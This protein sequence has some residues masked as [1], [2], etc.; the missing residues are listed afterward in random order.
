[1]KDV[2]YEKTAEFED[3]HFWFIGREKICF[4]LIDSIIYNSSI[5]RILDYGCGTG[6][7][8]KKLQ[9]TYQEKVIYGADI[10]DKALEYCQ[11]KGISNIFN[12]RETEPQ[13]TCFDLVI[14]LDVLEHVD[15]DVELLIRIKELLRDG[16]KLLITVPA[17]E[18][19]W[20]GEDYVSEHVRR[21][22][23]KMLREKLSEAGFHT[24]KIS[25]FNTLLFL[26]L[27]SVLLAKCL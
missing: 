20:S 6:N 2:A 12:L 9:K 18:F 23:R 8:L 13:I 26:P 22:T 25:Y 3:V 4:N 27:V 24:N 21:Y 11:R 1:M 5:Q 16:G 14:C 10:S 15:E 17:Y 7:L 19:L